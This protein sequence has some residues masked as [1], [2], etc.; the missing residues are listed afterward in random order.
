MKFTVFSRF[1]ENLVILRAKILLQGTKIVTTDNL[2]VLPKILGSQVIC[3]AHCCVQINYF[4]CLPILS[5]I[6]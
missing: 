3:T 1:Q 5:V 2:A 6:A 4:R